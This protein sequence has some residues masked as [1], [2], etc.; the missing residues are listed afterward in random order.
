M[1]RRISSKTTGFHKFAAPILLV[2]LVVL[3]IG[4]IATRSPTVPIWNL[5]LV[6]LFA[7]LICAPL[8]GF[9]IRL[10]HVNIDEEFL[11]IGNGDNGEKI[12]L[13]H[14]AEV[15]QTNWIKPFPVT[16]RLAGYSDRPRKILFIPQMQ[17]L[18]G[19]RNHPIVAEL[20]RLKSTRSE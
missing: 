15:K 3:T 19:A 10:K 13:A 17:G 9:S 6:T 2:A 8:I 11:C 18:R 16:I 14:I 20:N 5:V 1:R 12:P 4:I 7:A